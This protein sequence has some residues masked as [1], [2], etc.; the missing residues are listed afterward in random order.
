[1]SGRK[2]Q[3]AGGTNDS[4]AHIDATNESFVPDGVGRMEGLE[5][6]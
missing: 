3:V 2:Q 1:V 5:S 6:R 4:F